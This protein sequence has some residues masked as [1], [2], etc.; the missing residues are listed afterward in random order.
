[1][2]PGR[3]P[4]GER[5]HVVHA[6]VL[7]HQAEHGAEAVDPR[8]VGLADQREQDVGV[9]PGLA[10]EPVPVPGAPPAARRSRPQV[11]TRCA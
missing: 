3:V 4:G 10:R 5:R 7:E 9:D 11:A 2:Q 1:M 6:Q 8:Q